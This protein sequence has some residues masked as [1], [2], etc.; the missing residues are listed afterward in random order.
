MNRW[1][2]VRLTLEVVGDRASKIG[3]KVDGHV[4]NSVP[5]I[6]NSKKSQTGRTWSCG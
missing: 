5:G 6:T 2:I 3:R 1:Q 4:Q